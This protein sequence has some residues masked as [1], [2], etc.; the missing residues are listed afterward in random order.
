MSERM[1]LE[2]TVLAIAS[3]LAAPRFV[4]ALTTAIVGTG[5]F[6][7][8]LRQMMGW[9]G[10]IATI[11]TL[12]I[13]A[14]ASIVARRSSI[15]WRG[16]LPISLLVFL[17]WATI[18]IFWSHYHWA[19]LG[20]LAYLGA[21]TIL[22]LY[23]ALLRDTIQIVRA[24]GDVL[25]F[26]LAVS[27][28]IEVLSGIL[29]DTPIKFLLVLGKIS[30][31]G[32]IQGIS[33][34][35]NQLGIVAVIALITFATEYRTHLVSRTTSV[36]SLGGAALVLALTR[37]PL[38]IGTLLLV[39]V[40]A[41]AL[42]GLRRVR[43][44]RQR[45][46]QI[47][48]LAVTTVLG[49]VAWTSRSM[50]I[51]FFNVSGELTYRLNVWHTLW[52]LTALNPLQGWGWIGQWRDDIAPFPLFSTISARENTSASNAFL[53]VWFQLGLVGIA[54]FAVMVALTFVR[55][56]LLASRQRS[57]V[58][59]WPALALIA[60]VASALAESSMLTEFGWLTF[61]ACCVKAAGEL[62]WRTALR[63]E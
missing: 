18:S 13:L 5:V 3:F 31:F 4:T 42:C 49:V 14:A 56:W 63:P 16:L 11:A 36:F 27:L 43:P 47:A 34:A 52:D 19:T 24:Y 48:L 12:V 2:E 39:G 17:G 21:F 45:S 59:A 9:G 38:A 55:S 53:D 15:E 28:A 32:P 29:I 25:R 60:L 61:V 44:D 20:G 41:T 33:G 30:E 26:T 50:I 51:A 23:A 22:G 10:L 8:A 54:I 7:F 57:I 46:W 58:F 37:S 40:G 62:S 6:A 1:T 35:R